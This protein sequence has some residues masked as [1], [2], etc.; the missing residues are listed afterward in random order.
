MPNKKYNSRG[1]YSVYKNHLEFIH[2][3][4]L[5]LCFVSIYTCLFNIYLCDLCDDSDYMLLYNPAN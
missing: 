2:Q 3:V 1:C 5:Y 4:N